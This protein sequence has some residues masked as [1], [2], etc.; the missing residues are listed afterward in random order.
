MV[1][2]VDVTDEMKILYVLVLQHV[3]VTFSLDTFDVLVV[4]N[5]NCLDKPISLLDIHF[6][7]QYSPTT[8]ECL[9]CCRLSNT[10]LTSIANAVRRIA[11]ML[12][13]ISVIQHNT[14]HR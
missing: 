12:Q 4:N 8:D 10:N 13:T 7:V 9:R 3:F 1:T 14:H 2:A 5:R 6:S 11:V